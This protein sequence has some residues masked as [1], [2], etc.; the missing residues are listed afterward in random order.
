[1]WPSAA[2]E[3][4]TPNWWRSMST[5]P[6]RTMLWFRAREMLL[7][8]HLPPASVILQAAQRDR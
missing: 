2:R 3:G 4:M 5:H 7:T 6:A 8:S 1:M